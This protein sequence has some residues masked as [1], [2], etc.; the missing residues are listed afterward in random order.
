[1]EH[2]T[3]EQMIDSKMREWS[4]ADTDRFVALVNQF[5]EYR[6]HIAYAMLGSA[7]AVADSMGCDV[8]G[9]LVKLRE[10]APKPDVL[11][12]PQKVMS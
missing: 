4:S 5:P 11:F 12:P 7:I 2:G 8:E 10:H 6:R 1:M 3:V 9:F